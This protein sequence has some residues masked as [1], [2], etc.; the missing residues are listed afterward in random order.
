MYACLGLSAVVFIIHG[1]LMYGWKTQLNRMSLDRMGLMALL[2]LTGAYMYA[3]R[4]SYSCRSDEAGLMMMQIPEK[5]YPRKYDIL[6]N[7]HQILHVMVIFAGLAH[8]DG[9]LRAF[10]FVHS[11][12]L[13]CS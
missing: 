8:M 6:G 13:T 2:N 11:R 7:S 5:W 10:R 3:A 4:V 12:A 1:L 9:L